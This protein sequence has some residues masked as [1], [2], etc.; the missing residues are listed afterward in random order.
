MLYKFMNGE[1]MFKELRSL[2]REILRQHVSDIGYINISSRLDFGF[3]VH[4]IGHINVYIEIPSSKRILTPYG[5][6]SVEHIGPCSSAVKRFR[7]LYNGSHTNA[8]D[9]LSWSVMV[10]PDIINIINGI[11]STVIM[12]LEPFILFSDIGHG[13]IYRLD[14]REYS[15]IIKVCRFRDTINEIVRLMNEVI[16]GRV[17]MPKKEKPGGSNDKEVSCSS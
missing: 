3:S 4:G 17:R 1:N 2:Y 13:G 14:C 9:I 12:P 11:E 10:K 15:D 8:A 16:N 7:T 5:E 6:L